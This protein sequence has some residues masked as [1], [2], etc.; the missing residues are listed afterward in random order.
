MKKETKLY[1]ALITVIFMVISMFTSIVFFKAEPQIPL[2]FGCMIAGLVAFFI[3]YSWDDIL[4]GM[5]NGIY[6]SLEAILILLLIGVLVA[7]WIAGGTVPTM[8]YYGLKIVT[9]SGFLPASMFLC[10]L[11][12]FAIGSWG[13]VGT[14]GLAFM[15]IGMALNLPAPLVAGA[16]ISGA[17]MGEVIS[18]L[19]DATNLCAAVVRENVFDI[20][21]KIIPP[22]SFVAIISLLIYAIKG[23]QC[24]GKDTVAIKN[25]IQPLLEN[26]ASQFHIS[27]LNLLP[28]IAM[29]VFILL[30]VPAIPAMLAGGICGMLEAVLFQGVKMEQ[31]LQYSFSGYISQSGNKMIDNL[32]TAGG[33]EE[34]LYPI[35]I[36]IIAMSFGGIMQCSGQ[37]ES[38]VK[39]IASR[40]SSRAGINTATVITCIGMNIILPDQYLGISMPGQMYEEEYEKRKISKV[41]LATTLLGGGAVTSPLV[42]WNTCGI[43]CMTIL[44]VTP[45]AYGRY[46]YYA[47]LLPVA[48]VIY[49]FLRK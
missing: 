22:A 39:P 46:A 18:P 47:I 30:K 12:A 29:I 27:P 43:Y 23:F 32:L 26:I 20:V 31:I 36:I 48:F 44:G 28:M 7:S 1:Y 10:M 17:Y 16:I 9:P 38:L 4:Q 49:S 15:G 42:P 35:S 45:M 41:E 33:M 2:V 37:M 11:V 19:S 6:Q 40:I 13:T 3:G 5:L 34:M 24:G 14:V 8:I 25:S 21:K